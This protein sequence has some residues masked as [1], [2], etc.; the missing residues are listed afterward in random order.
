M[1]Q[2]AGLCAEF[3]GQGAAVWQGGLVLVQQRMVVVPGAGRL[4]YSDEAFRE[5]GGGFGG[6]ASN[7][8]DVTGGLAGFAD[9]VE[10]V[11]VFG[12]ESAEGGGQ[13]GLCDVG[14]ASSAEVEIG[15]GRED[16]AEFVEVSADIVLVSSD[17]M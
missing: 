11:V 14:E 10:V 13:R 2:A 12:I 3:L 7:L 8:G 17:E 5:I 1:P 6:F 9:G 4:L 16:W 15:G